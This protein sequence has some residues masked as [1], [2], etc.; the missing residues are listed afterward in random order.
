MIRSEALAIRNL[1]LSYGYPKDSANKQFISHHLHQEWMIKFLFNSKLRSEHTFLDIG[2]GW[3]RLADVLLPYLE[4]GNYYGIEREQVNLDMGLEWIYRDGAEIPKPNL[5]CNPNFDF[6]KFATTF[7]FAFSYA[8]F[9]HLSHDEIER[10][11]TNTIQVMKLGGSFYF[12]F[13]L[14][15]EDKD[16]ESIYSMSS[17]KKIHYYSAHL[18]LDYFTALFKRLNLRWKH[19]GKQ[20]HPSNHDIIQV[21][22]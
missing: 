8:V 17:G 1:F 14:S 9:T 10:C 13:Y 22:Y 5:L 12:T 19:L 20:D 6:E 11:I 4:S 15:N 7:D 2:C 16:V 3:L 21:L 18:T